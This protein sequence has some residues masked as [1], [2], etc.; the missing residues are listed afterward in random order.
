M[1]ALIIALALCCPQIAF[2]QEPSETSDA[3]LYIIGQ[4]VNAKF[5]GMCGT[6]RQLASFQVSTQMDGGSEFML[7]FVRTEAARLGY[8]NA[9][10]LMAKCQDSIAEYEDTKQLLM[11][12]ANSP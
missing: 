2:S 9:D 10:A 8:E 12:S 3:S 7:R 4:L 6:I 5:T 1:R 11:G